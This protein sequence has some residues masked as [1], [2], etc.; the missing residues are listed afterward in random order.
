MTRAKFNRA[1]TAVLSVGFVLFAAAKFTSGYDVIQDLPEWA[2]Y[3]VGF[4]ELVVAV[5]L[6]TQ[7]ERVVR[8]VVLFASTLSALSVFFWPTARCG[9]MGDIYLTPRQRIVIL[10]VTG[11]L[12][13]FRE[14]GRRSP[15][16][17]ISSSTND[18]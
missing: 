8:L 6:W 7:V 10:M 13:A 9:C 11:F 15:A 1:S 14:F 18:L 17:H 12:A 2:F 4:L 16:E 5:L 3:L